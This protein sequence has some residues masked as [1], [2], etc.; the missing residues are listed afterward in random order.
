VSSAGEGDFE[1]KMNHYEILGVSRSAKAVEI[2]TAFHKLAKKYH[3]DKNPESG[4]TDKLR[5]VFTGN[6][7]PRFNWATT[8]N[9]TYLTF[10]LVAAY[11]VLSDPL[12]RAN[13][14][15]DLN[16]ITQ[17]SA[18]DCYEES[19]NFD[20]GD[21]ITEKANTGRDESQSSILQSRQTTQTFDQINSRSRSS[22][23]INDKRPAGLSFAI[24]LLVLMCCIA[25]W[26]SLGN[27][28]SGFKMQKE[29]IKGI[30]DSWR[31][32]KNGHKKDEGLWHGI[33]HGIRIQ[34]ERA[35]KQIEK[36]VEKGRYWKDN[37]SRKE[38]KTYSHSRYYQSSC[39]G[40]RIY[41][42]Y[43]VTCIGRSCHVC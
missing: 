7:K 3:P 4:T 26:Y 30:A 29:T 16:D 38:Q 1:P 5:R 25:F 12:Q 20:R 35:L 18:C 42:S 6:N 36:V 21:E 31:R 40:N 24:I 13:Y 37:I 41:N 14:D 22:R 2:K 8:G 32:F 27:N 19:A 17:S 23:G 34:K 43:C 10:F 28:L 33:L 39:S 11:T 15:L 9:V